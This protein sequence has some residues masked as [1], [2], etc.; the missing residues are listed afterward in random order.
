MDNG[1]LPIYKCIIP[2]L[3]TYRWQQVGLVGYQQSKNDIN[4][5]RELIK[6]FTW[7]FRGSNGY[8]CDLFYYIPG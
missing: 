3:C 7:R 8:R 2:H 4:W 6:E 5:K 1:R